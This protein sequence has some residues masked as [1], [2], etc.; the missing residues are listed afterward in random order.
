[1]KAF[2]GI[3]FPFRINSKGGVEMSCVESTDVAHIEEAIK[4]ILLTAPR[5][6]KMEY[7]FKSELSTSLFEPG[8]ASAKSL[9]EHQIRQALGELE[10]RISISSVT[11]TTDGS[12][13]FAT[14]K[15]KVIIYYDAEFTYT[16]KV[17]EITQ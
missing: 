1:M 11:V 2:N 6:R 16:T 12:S 9:V 5:E 17:G 10:D 15:Y 3:S 4:Q 13:I 14:I 7:H 8:N